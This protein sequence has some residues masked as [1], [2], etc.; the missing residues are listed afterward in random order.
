MGDVVEGCALYL[1]TLLRVMWPEIR[2]AGVEEVVP[3]ADE[4]VDVARL[5]RPLQQAHDDWDERVSLDRTNIESEVRLVDAPI[6]TLSAKGERCRNDE[7]DDRHHETCEGHGDKF[8]AKKGRAAARGTLSASLRLYATSLTARWPAPRLCLAGTEVGPCSAASTA[9][10]SSPPIASPTAA[11]PALSSAPAA[12][13]ASTPPATRGHSLRAWPGY[14]G[15][16]RGR[17]GARQRDPLLPAAAG[18]PRRRGSPP[19]PCCSAGPPPSRARAGSTASPAS[20]LGRRRG[21]DPGLQSPLLRPR[22]PR[23]R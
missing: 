13:P 8:R 14:R 15:R 20:A 5:E 18:R 22:P 11:S 10:T 7:R 17:P 2:T 16:R 12:G 19:P 9:T 6:A 3:D 21:S 1:Y 4:D 23:W